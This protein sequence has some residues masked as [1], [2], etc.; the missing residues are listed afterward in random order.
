MKQDNVDTPALRLFAGDPDSYRRAANILQDGGL[1]AFPT[2]TVYGLGAL[3]WNEASIARMYA[4][5]E[6]PREKAI[7]ILVAGVEEARR[8]VGEL[9]SV[10]EALIQR[11]WPGPLTI[12]VPCGDRLPD[13]IT[14]GTGAVA[15]RAPDH[16][17]TLRLLEEIGQPLAVT[18]ANRSG[19]TDPLAAGD[20]FAQLGGRI[21]AVLDGGQCPGGRPSTVLSAAVEPPRVLRSGPIEPSDLSEA[22]RQAGF[23]VRVAN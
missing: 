2:D 23:E 11:F 9:P 1:V 7:P 19:A 10:A 18:S 6:R 14:S 4:A 5:K 3:I 15:L 8:L 12:V 22:L 17:V 21:D 20:V 16:P 13:G